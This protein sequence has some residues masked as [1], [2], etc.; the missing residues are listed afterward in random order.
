M[1]ARVVL[2][3]ATLRGP[4]NAWILIVK[5]IVFTETDQEDMDE[6][7]RSC[8]DSVHEF[9]V[10][11]EPDDLLSLLLR[12]EEARQTGRTLRESA[13]ALTVPAIELNQGLVDQTQKMVDQLGSLH[14]RL[15]DRYVDL[16]R[17]WP[18]RLR[19]PRLVSW[20]PSWG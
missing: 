11:L 19:R 2:I 14:R 3:E 10:V 7:W 12:L 5:R 18:G 8:R 1:T 4:I 13:E 15:E 9:E 20:V 6:A 16:G 17:G